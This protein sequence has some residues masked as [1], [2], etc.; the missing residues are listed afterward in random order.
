VL[1]AAGYLALLPLAG[2]SRYVPALVPAAAAAGLWVGTGPL[3]I[4]TLGP[5]ESVLAH[6]EGVMAAVSI[7]GDAAGD[8][9]LKVDSHFQGGTTSAFSDLRQGHLPLLLHPAPREALYLGLGTAGTFAAAAAHPGL[10]AEGVELVPEI[11]PLLHYFQRSTGDLGAAPGLSVVVADARRY[12]TATPRTF[13][14]VVADLFHPARDGAAALYTR[15]HFRGIRSRLAEGGVFVQWLPLYQLDLETFRTIARTFLDVFP[16]GSAWLA[17]FSLRT[18]I[19]GL[20]GAAVPVA[21]SPG[22]FA[23]RVTDA[24][25]ATALAR[26]RLHDDLGL[27]GGFLAGGAALRT[28]CG[29]GP[30]NTDDLPRVLFE[31]PRQAYAGGGEPAERL[32]ALLAGLSADPAD[33]LGPSRDDGERR[34][35]A[36]LAAYWRA[37]DLYLRAG[38]RV[39]ET[40][41]PS[42]LLAQVRAPL[43]AALRE[44]PEF[45]P[46]ALP[47]LAIAERLRAHDRA[48]ADAL[49]EDLRRAIPG[50]GPRATAAP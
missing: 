27:F 28:F 15:E 9:H 29:A 34:D 13:D 12:V 7:I 14:V 45:E 5:G 1:C 2:A 26:V 37:R 31:A 47:L 30:L 18:P 40:S 20:V 32:L 35:H 4:V 10:R 16:D 48:A 24:G 17:H 22:W 33:V 11:V 6:V 36:R 21:R 46:A 8:R 19:V 44:S 49:L 39:R 25:L 50:S 41:D 23:S 43:L 42:A 3:R 38:V